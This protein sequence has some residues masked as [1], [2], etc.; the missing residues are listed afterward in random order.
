MHTNPSETVVE[1][2]QATA[3]STSS[4]QPRAYLN[5]REMC[6]RLGVSER[7][8]HRIR[9]EDWMPR[10]I[11]LSPQVLR[12]S[13]AEVDQAMRQ[14]APRAETAAPA[15]AQLLRAKIDRMKSTGESA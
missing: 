14:R 2:F 10:P 11:A 6:D 12:W 15:P 4:Y 1:P 13:L 8:F 9:N 5:V 3:P 7:T